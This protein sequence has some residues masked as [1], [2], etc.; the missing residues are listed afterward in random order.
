[1]APYLAEN[2]VLR[3]ATLCVL[4]AAQG[5]PDGFVRTALKNYLYDRG[6][7]VSAAGTIITMVSWP[8]MMKWAWGP[9]IDRFGYPPMGRRRPWILFAQGM[10]GV[11]LVGMMLIPDVATDLRL[12]AAIVLV[13]NVFASLQDV[14][15]DALAVDLLPASE[16]G[17]AN[18][19]MYAASFAGNFVGGKIL[20][21]LLVNHGVA[22]AVTVQIA[23]LAVIGLFPVVFRERRGDY[24]LPR[25]RGAAS[26]AH[27]PAWTRPESL[28]RV[29]VML[30]QAYSLR[31]TR[32]GAVLAGLTLL[33]VNAHF[34]YWPKYVQESLGWTTQEWLTLE[35]GWGSAFGFAGCL[36]GGLAASVFG[37]KRVV[38]AALGALSV[39]WLTYGATSGWWHERTVISALY[40]IESTLAGTVQVALFALFMGICWPA[41]A[42]TQFTSYMA[43]MNLANV[44]GAKFAADISE[45]FGIVH[46]HTALAALQLALVGVAAAIDPDETRRL[47]GD[48]FP[49]GQATA[50]DAP[51]IDGGLVFPPEPPR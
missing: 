10:M 11:S 37:A 27:I 1:M 36:I 47:M 20:G 12:L 45:G 22:S 24:L 40:M 41:V 4:Y 43:L 17:A 34:V 42:A 14:S 26:R 13:V 28:Q 44:L 49:A 6:V 18:G 38:L 15:V 19:F 30:G 31:S 9:F 35:G 2:R 33:T 50:D 8:W 39:C 29:F 16:R 3:L 5:M 32:L 21:D 25:L 51:E 48:G 7:S 46:S 23:I